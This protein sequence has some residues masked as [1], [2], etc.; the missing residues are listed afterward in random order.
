MREGKNKNKTI[1]SELKKIK[2]LQGL[3]DEKLEL[4][5]DYLLNLSDICYKIYANEKK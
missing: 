3:S 5:G 4:I 2:S 1:I